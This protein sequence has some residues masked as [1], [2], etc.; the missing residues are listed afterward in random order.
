MNQ[1]LSA[2]YS[3]VSDIALLFGTGALS[4]FVN[5]LLGTGGGIV[6]VLFFTKIYAKKSPCSTKDIFAMTL[7]SS[8]IMSF[9]SAVFYLRG[10]AFSLSDAA[11][12]ILPAVVG[13]VLGA[14]LLEKLSPK[15]FKKLFSLL[16]VWAGVSMMVKL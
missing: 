2:K 9:S 11:P 1:N 5:G 8:A 14:F 15:F 10:G 7:V 16:V 3:T 13:G 12:Y 6:T 4:G